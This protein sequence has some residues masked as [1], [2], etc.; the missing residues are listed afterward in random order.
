[1]LN[2]KNII[3]GLLLILAQVAVFTFA[4]SA[5]ADDCDLHLPFGVPSGGSGDKVL[6]YAG[7]ALSYDYEMKVPS[8]VSYSLTKKSVHGTNVKRKNNFKIDQNLPRQFASSGSDYSRS[9]YDRGHMV[10]SAQID[11]SRAA[12]DE[13]FLYSNMAPQLA[14][15][16]RDMMGHEGAW[17]RVEGL[18]RKWVYKHDS[19]MVISGTYF[20]DEPKYIGN[21]V[22]VPSSF[23]KIILNPTT[24]D[25]VSFWFPH[26]EDTGDQIASYIVSIDEIEKRTGI[27]F[28]ARV[29][30]AQENYVEKKIGSL[31]F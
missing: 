27:D 23:Y 1:M 4:P 29:D 30:D 24:G 22:G 18:V 17:G 19:L 13:T 11:Y 20:N 3:A 16:N 2:S 26:V 9:G 12:N 15:F 21:G 7:F 14:G 10:G 28:L 31:R 6:C 25:T 5:L 8:W